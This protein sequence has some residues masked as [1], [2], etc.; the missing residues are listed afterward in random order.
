LVE[1]SDLPLLRIKDLKNNTVEQYIDPNNFP[2]NALVNVEDIIYTRTG[3]LGLVFRG[4]KGVLHNNSF[5]VVPN[6]N[7]DKD[8]LFI[9]LQNPVFKAKIME[10]ALKAA[11][12]DITHAIFKIQEIAIPTL[13][14]QQGIVCQLDALRAET[15][16][17]EAV[18]QN[19]ISGLAD[20][21][22]SFLQKAFSGEL[23]SA[24]SLVS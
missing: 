12:P 2:K 13:K 22:K 6:E 10:L 9:W 16:K 7:L 4:R 11:Q 1:K 18:Y 17:L 15:Q 23:T 3:S 8:Y 24:K 14:E 5:K 20:L 21:K 19:R